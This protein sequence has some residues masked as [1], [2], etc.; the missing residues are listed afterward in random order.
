MNSRSC[1]FVALIFSIGVSAQV[2]AANEDRKALRA[3]KKW[4]TGSWS[5]QAGEMPLRLLLPPG[6]GKGRGFFEATPCNSTDRLSQVEM[7]SKKVRLRRRGKLLIL[8]GTFTWKRTSVSQLGSPNWPGPFNLKAKRNGRRISISGTLK[9]QSGGAIRSGRFSTRTGGR[10]PVV[11][12]PWMEMVYVGNPGNGTDPFLPNFPTTGN[13]ALGAVPYNFKIAK[14]EITNQQF[15]EFLNAVGSSDPNSIYSLLMGSNARGGISRSGGDGSYSYAAKPNMA[16]KPVAFISFWNACRFCNWMHNGRP[17]GTQGNATTEDGAYTLTAGTITANSVFRNPNAQYFIPAENE[18]HKAAFHF[19]GGGD[20]I[21]GGGGARYNYVRY[22]TGH[23][24]SPTM[25]GADLEGNMII[26]PPVDATN[27]A[28]HGKGADWGAQ[29]GNV[30][31]VGSG[32][33]GSAS[34]YGAYDLAGNVQEW[35]ETKWEIGMDQ[36]RINRGGAWDQ[37]A[38][39]SFH[40]RYDPPGEVHP[41]GYEEAFYGLRIATYAD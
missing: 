5:N 17:T 22:A 13:G 31:T 41:N 8:S 2:K 39:L 37:S 11:A 30:T 20:V 21:P 35:T 26:S 24:T 23:N 10:Y 25:A 16:N 38:P 19:P 33:P 15:V 27:I 7:K 9:V 6:R 40:G 1:I 4:T 29:D 28:N 32:G 18:W 36:Y 34:F 12:S 14:Y 3:F